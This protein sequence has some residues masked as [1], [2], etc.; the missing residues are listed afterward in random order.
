MGCKLRECPNK[1]KKDKEAN[2]MKAKKIIIGVAAG[3]I[4]L[5]AAG[6]TEIMEIIGKE[7]TIHRVKVAI[8]L[9][10]K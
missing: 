4:T 1:L 10:S 6:A 7:E 3:L 2:V 5:I 8:E 9:L